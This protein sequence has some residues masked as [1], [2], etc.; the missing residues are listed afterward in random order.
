MSLVSENWGCGE[1]DCGCPSQVD[2][3]LVGDSLAPRLQHLQ[4][5]VAADAGTNPL[6]P[7]VLLLLRAGLDAVV[8]VVPDHHLPILLGLAGLDQGPATQLLVQADLKD[9]L[10]W[11]ERGRADDYTHIKV[12]YGTT[13]TTF[14][15]CQ[16]LTLFHCYTSQTLHVV[17]IASYYQNF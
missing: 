12:E 11:R 5:G 7:L 10:W 14:L 6:H 2:G 15:K 9:V 8:E 13:H 4:E 16:Q 1:C 3:A 17:P